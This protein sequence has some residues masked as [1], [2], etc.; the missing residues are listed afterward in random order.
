MTTTPFTLELQRPSHHHAVEE[1]LDRAFG[2]DRRTKTS[3]RL[4]EGEDLLDELCMTA[5]AGDRLVG[6]IWYSPLR[7]GPAGTHAL[8][9]GPLAVS[10]DLQN[11]GIGMKLMRAT[12]ADAADLGH[13]LV[14]LV[15][16]EPYYQRVGFSRVPDGRLMLPGPVDPK[17]LLYRELTAGA[18]RDVGGLVLGP[19]RWAQVQDLS[20]LA[21]PGQPHQAQKQRERCQS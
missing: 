18:F 11:C 13:Q 5:W 20:S 1:L 16:D 8:L 15:G 2:L 4:R 3:Y 19:R 17:R 7:I 6:S 12:L 21:I 9:L 10:P 14:I